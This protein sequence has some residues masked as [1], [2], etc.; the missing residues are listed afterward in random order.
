M[1]EPDPQFKLVILG[2]SNVGKTCIVHRFANESFLEGSTP[3]IGANFLTKQMTL[4]DGKRIKLEVWDTAGQERYKSLTPMYYKGSSAA[5][6]IYDITQPSTLEGAKDWIKELKNHG[7]A[8]II[9]G[10]VGNKLDLNRNVSK[11]TG[12]DTA[13]RNMSLFFEVSAK[14]GENISEMFQEIAN[15]LPKDPPRKRQALSQGEAKKETSSCCN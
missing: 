8:N 1:V 15:R 13:Q 2:N 9:V 14:T 12:M 10:L 11:E 6:I 3:T 7:P 4:S 5:L